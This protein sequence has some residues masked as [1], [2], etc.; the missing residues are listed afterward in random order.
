MHLT[1]NTNSFSWFAVTYPL[2]KK[3]VLKYISLKKYVCV[4]IKFI[5]YIL[6]I[7]LYYLYYYILLYSCIK[8]FIPMILQ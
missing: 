8:E 1:M 2:L 5:Y 3:I 6:F 4:F 7:L